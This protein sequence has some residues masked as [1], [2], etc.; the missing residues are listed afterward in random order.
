MEVFMMSRKQLCSR[1]L[2]KLQ[3]SWSMLDKNNHGLSALLYYYLS[4]NYLPNF[5]VSTKFNYLQYYSYMYEHDLDLITGICDE[6]SWIENCD[7]S[8]CIHGTTCTHKM[9]SNSPLNAH[10]T[11]AAEAPWL[12]VMGRGRMT[13]VLWSGK[14]YSITA[15]L[16]L[17]VCMFP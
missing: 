17:M 14:P 5:T 9:P 15:R 6:K 16:P 2:N 8:M 7:Q 13:Y 12:I 3:H 1:P 11:T 4:G 10:A